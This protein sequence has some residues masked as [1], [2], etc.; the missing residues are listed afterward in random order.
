MYR[1]QRDLHYR[2]CSA[3]TRIVQESDQLDLAEGPVK[4]PFGQLPSARGF[5]AQSPNPEFEKQAGL[6]LGSGSNG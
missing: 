6:I 4:E 2:D 1:W 3:G 5:N